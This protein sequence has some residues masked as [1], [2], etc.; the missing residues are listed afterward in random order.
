[1]FLGR[2]ASGKGQPFLDRVGGRHGR[3]GAGARGKRRAR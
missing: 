2:L 3:R 1:L